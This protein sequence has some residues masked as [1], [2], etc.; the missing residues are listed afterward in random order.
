[1]IP[2]HMFS[3]EFCKVFKDRFSTTEHEAIAFEYWNI[4]IQ[5]AG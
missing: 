3:F 1:M 5:N 2:L 4:A